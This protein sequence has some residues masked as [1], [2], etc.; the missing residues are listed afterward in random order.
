MEIKS[1]TAKAPAVILVVMLLSMMAGAICMNKV[2]PIL[3]NIT[4]DL[5][6]TDG[7]LSGLL[8]SIFTFSGI[9]LSIPMGVLTT[10]YGFF[11]TGLFS[12]IMMVAGSALGAVSTTYAVLFIS[13]FIEGIGMMFIGTIGP[14][15]IARVYAGRNT[16]SAMGILMC[17]MAFGQTFA[18]NIAPI[19][20]ENSRWQNFWWISTAFALVAMVLWIIVVRGIDGRTA[21]VSAEDT[22]ND[23]ERVSF[24]KVVGNKSIMLVCLCFFTFMTAH[25]G[26]FNYLPTYFTEVGGITATK[27]GSLT[28]ISSLIGIPVGILGGVIADKVGSI[29]KPLALNMTAFAVVIAVIPMFTS[30]SYLLL[31]IIYGVVAMAEAGLSFTA[32]ALVSEA[33]E[34]AMGSA[35]L[36]TAM[37]L[38]AFLSTIVFGTLLDKFG[39]NISF[40]CMIPIV[41]VGAAAIIVNKDLK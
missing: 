3:I 23:G 31:T 14:A 30:R 29:K 13:R 7:T 16:G 32:V 24:G 20:A 1:N 8:I 27:A 9:L 17:Y 5:N 37:W 35:A 34:A 26:I 21:D 15:V 38:G 22:G 18:L 12:L 39:W 40:F 33:K 19:V 41:L 25:M 36:N 28:S 6:I 10:K 11:K 4:D 2:A